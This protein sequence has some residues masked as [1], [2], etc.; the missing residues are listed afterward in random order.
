MEGTPYVAVT[1]LTIQIVGLEM[2]E[3]PKALEKPPPVPEEE[4]E[5]EEQGSGDEDPDD[6]D[7][8]TATPPPPPKRELVTRRVPIFLAVVVDADPPAKLPT[9][10]DLREFEFLM[11]RYFY[12]VLKN[13][14]R[15]NLVD[16]RLEELE[17]RFDAGIPE[18]RFNLCVEYDATILFRDE[19]TAP[20]KKTLK[21][22]I[23]HVNLSTILAHIR[24][25]EPRCFERAS[26]VSMRKK[27]KK[28][29]HEKQKIKDAGKSCRVV[30][31]TGTEWIAVQ[32]NRGYCSRSCCVT[33]VSSAIRCN[34]SRTTILSTHQII[35]CCF[36]IK[37][38][39]SR[40]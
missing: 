35:I 32:C 22:L 33:E 8:E 13:E 18:T 25:L 5:E 24:D 11:L 14:Y 23:F 16:M 29:K 20:D 3:A 9:R 17:T 2:P 26:E 1:M 10:S 4:N 27:P 37:T 30:N 38:Q 36:S 34:D 31:W 39:C 19:K 7:S 12:T 28:Q 21:K 6:D 40:R 15:D